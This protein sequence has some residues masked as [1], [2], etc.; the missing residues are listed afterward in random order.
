MCMKPLV[1]SD[2]S[3]GEVQSQNQR[4]KN[5]PPVC[6]DR[7]KFYSFPQDVVVFNLSM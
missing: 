6:G 7:L 5:I 1:F 2:T 3:G 4:M